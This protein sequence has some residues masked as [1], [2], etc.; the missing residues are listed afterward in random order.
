MKK[1]EEAPQI[2]V[3]YTLSPYETVSPSRI[4]TAEI[5]FPS[6]KSFTSATPAAGVDA[7]VAT[8]E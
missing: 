8:T 7:I 3:R 6:F 5:T 1:F 4:F 2:N